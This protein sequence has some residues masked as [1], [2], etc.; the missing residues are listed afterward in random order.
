MPLPNGNLRG[1]THSIRAELHA[2]IDAAQHYE[3]I[4]AMMRGSALVFMR[5]EPTRP[6]DYQSYIYYIH[7]LHKFKLTFLVLRQRHEGSS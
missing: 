3:F 6:S 1:N 7:I 4:T 5:D 2:H